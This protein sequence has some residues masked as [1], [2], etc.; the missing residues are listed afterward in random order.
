[1]TSVIVLRASSPSM[2]GGRCFAS[3]GSSGTVR[4]VPRRCI[5]TAADY[6][7][8]FVHA[9]HFDRIFDIVYDYVSARLARTWSSPSC[10][11]S[12]SPS[13]SSA[14][15]SSGSSGLAP[16]RPGLPRRFVQHHLVAIV[17]VHFYPFV[18]SS[19]CGL[20]R[21]S[22]SSPFFCTYDRRGGLLCWSLRQRRLGGALSLARPVLATPVRA[23]VPDAFT[24]LANPGMCRSMACLRRLRHRLSL[25]LPRRVAVFV[26]GVVSVTP[27]PWRFLVRPRLPVRLLTIGDLD[28]SPSTTATLR[29]TSSTTATCSSSA[30]STSAQRATIR[31]SFSPVL[32]SRSIRIAPTLQLQG[33]V[34]PSV[35]TFGFPSSLTVC[36]APAVTTGDVRV[37]LVV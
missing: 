10:S 13:S 17:A 2:E 37:Y 5:F 15:A 7:L 12:S 22:S 1:M 30:S 27:P 36:S 11:S 28:S 35:P 9:G 26:S 25:R 14:A 23:I 3:S 24:G 29:T 8:D 34:S 31:M 4:G 16:D 18:Y 19:N 20:H 6:V 33:D 21:A 32:S